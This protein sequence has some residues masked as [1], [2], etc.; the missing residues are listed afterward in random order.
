LVET[1]K[2]R[3][4]TGQVIRI[5]VSNRLDGPVT[6]R[7]Q[8]SFCTIIDLER[9][10]EGDDEWEEIRNCISGAP[11]REVILEPGSSHTVKL[12]VGPVPPEPLVSGRYRATLVYSHGKRFLLAEE[13]SHVARSATFH[14]A[15]TGG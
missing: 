12:A 1:D 15:Q 7:D 10:V 2:D 14:I 4:E 6:T 3:Y 5:Q 11:V 9:E 8:R 13:A